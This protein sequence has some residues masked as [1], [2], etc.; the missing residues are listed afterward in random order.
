MNK[1]VKDGNGYAT[2]IFESIEDSPFKVGK[3]VDVII[4]PPSTHLASMKEEMA[5]Y[6]DHL[7]IM[8]QYFKE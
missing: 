5:K 8:N 4:G 6:Q 7:D 2:S 3:D 1:T